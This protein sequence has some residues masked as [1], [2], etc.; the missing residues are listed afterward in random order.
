MNKDLRRDGAVPRW[1]SRGAATGKS[2]GAMGEEPANQPLLDHLAIRFID[3]G[4]SVKKL[5]RELKSG[6]ALCPGLA[7]LCYYDGRHDA[8]F[9]RRGALRRHVRRGFSPRV[10]SCRDGARAIL[11]HAWARRLC[12]GRD[13][14][15]RLQPKAPERLACLL[16]EPGRFR[17]A[18]RL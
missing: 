2:C 15:V 16:E 6:Q 17:P 9:Y 11:G 13:N 7:G 8:I 3:E 4:W 12:A 10:P 14:L 1:A 5:V 18:A